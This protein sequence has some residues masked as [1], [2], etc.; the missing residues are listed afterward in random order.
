[1]TP[2][3]EAQKITLIGAI[4][5]ALLGAIKIVIGSIAHSSALVADGI[6]SLSDL[7]T[8]FMVIVIL[9]YSHQEPDKEHPWGHA[10]FETLGT[11][12]LGG[13]L[14][15]V[16]GAIAYDSLHTLITGTQLLIP[17]WPTLLVAAI[18]VVAKEV[19][20]RYTLAIGKKLKSDLLIANAWHSR[21]DALSSVIVFV[22]IAG[23][24]SGF[25]WLDAVA[26]I[27]VGF[28]V[29]KIGIELSWK[30]VQELLDTALPEEDVQAYTDE[31]MQVEG[32]LSVHSFKSRRMASHILLEIHLQIA[33]YLTASEGHFIGDMAVYRLRA[34]FPD[35][36]HVIFHIDTYDD[37]A[38]NY[39]QVLPNRVEISRHIFEILDHLDA[40]ALNIHR[41]N[42]HYH[43]D[44]IE[45]DLQLNSRDTAAYE[46]PHLQETLNAEL[47]KHAWFGHLNLL[48]RY[49]GSSHREI[50]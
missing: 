6:H 4:L 38:E 18:S 44:A 30:C 42:L 35:I 7:L 31:I 17:E 5:D 49:T 26:A 24:M 13:L 47:S 40:T 43:T 29:A 21:T 32:I 16:A 27:L 25:A 2:Q 34:R 20:F 28:I 14:I 11:I 8:D 19:I 9:K 37:E 10:R 39:C 22:G 15:L 46:L 23:A 50:Q 48:V 1:M 36:K 41:L 3:S 45:I 12:I 33:P